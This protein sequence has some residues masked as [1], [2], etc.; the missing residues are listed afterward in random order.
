LVLVSPFNTDV[1]KNYIINFI[2]NKKWIGTILL[3]PESSKSQISTNPSNIYDL[4]NNL[5]NKEYEYININ[6]NSKIS[7]I[8]FISKFINSLSNN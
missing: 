2:S 4:E 1:L 5:K 8:L 7:K 6:K 3:L